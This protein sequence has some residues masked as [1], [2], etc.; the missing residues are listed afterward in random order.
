[1]VQGYQ[2]VP[3]VQHHQAGSLRRINSFRGVARNLGGAQGVYTSSPVVQTQ[4]TVGGYTVLGP[5]MQ[6]TVGGYHQDTMTQ[7]AAGLPGHPQE[8][9]PVYNEAGEIYIHNENF[10]Q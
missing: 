6:G 4:G 5:A 3:V 1:M 10:Q 9:E 8:S 2:S 7:G